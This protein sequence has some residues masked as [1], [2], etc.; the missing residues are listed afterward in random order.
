[1]NNNEIKLC[2]GNTVTIADIYYIADEYINNVLD[3]PDDIS[4]KRNCFYGLLKHIYNK[5]FEPSLHDKIL[6]NQSCLVLYSDIYSLYSLYDSFIDLCCKYKTEFTQNSFSFFSGIDVST[7]EDWKNNRQIPD[8]INGLPTNLWSEY[9][10]KIFRNSEIA[11]HNSMLDG[12]LMAYATLKCW[13]GWSE[14]PQQITITTQGPQVNAS[15]IAEKYKNSMLQ[16]LPPQTQT[17]D[18]P[19]QTQQSFVHYSETENV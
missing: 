9:A 17:I 6:N 1:M 5:L 15:M 19:E 12:N 8:N 10:K 4:K 3:N 16:P 7:L 13:Y 14:T 11:L 18:I 2:N